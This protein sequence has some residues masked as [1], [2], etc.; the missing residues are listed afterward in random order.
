MGKF[1]LM[2]VVM[3]LAAFYLFCPYAQAGGVGDYRPV[4]YWHVDF[5]STNVTTGAYVQIDA[6]TDSS[7]S[8]IHAFSSGNN[9]VK[10]AIGAASSE[11][12]IPYL[13]GDGYTPIA[14]KAGI[15][16][17][18]RLSVIAVGGTANSGYLIINCLQ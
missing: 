9:P 4:H 2:I 13:I 15:K 18:V 1:L 8:A 17:S 16:R 6:S 7:C 14:V 5:V 10:L 11:Q 3:V 12:D